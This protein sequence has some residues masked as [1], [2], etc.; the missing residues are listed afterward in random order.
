MPIR[1][2]QEVW[3]RSLSWEDP[4]EDVVATHSRNFA[5]GN[6]MDRKTWWATV[7]EV[8]KSWTWL[9]RAHTQTLK[10]HRVGPD[11]LLFI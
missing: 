5:W 1:K 8:A 9:N 11:K 4:V 7:Y 10:A 2:T 3:F 6:L